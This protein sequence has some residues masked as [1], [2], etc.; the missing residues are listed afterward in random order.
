MTTKK[1]EYLIDESV[2][3]EVSAERLE[4]IY[5]NITNDDDFEKVKKKLVEIDE[6]VDEEAEDED[7][8]KE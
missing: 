2:K 8:D 4:S 3:E 5:Q 1:N 7:A 6:L